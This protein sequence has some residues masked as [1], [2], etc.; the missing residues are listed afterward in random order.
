MSETNWLLSKQMM[1]QSCDVSVEAFHKWL[2]PSVEKRGVMVMYRV[3][4]VID[5]RVKCA[6]DKVLAKQQT[7]AKNG[8]TTEGVKTLEVERTRLVKAQADKTEL[9]LE[10]LRGSLVPADEVTAHWQQFIGSAR[11]KLLSMPSKLAGVLIACTDLNEIE[12][13]VEA[14]IYEALA[15][16][17]GT[18]L[19]NAKPSDEQ[20][21]DGRFGDMDASPETDSERVGGSVSDAKRGSQRRAGK[22]VN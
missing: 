12:A 13:A 3:K 10:A 14:S 8:V 9:E 4:D 5:N 17:A 15:E 18:G 19:P 11:A 6:V 7:A 22:V 1:A 16:L 2:V 20:D 21:L